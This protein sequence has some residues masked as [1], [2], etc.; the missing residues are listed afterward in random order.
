MYLII[1]QLV[2]IVGEL[3]SAKKQNKTRLVCNPATTA[4]EVCVPDEAEESRFLPSHLAQFLLCKS[5]PSL[6]HAVLCCPRLYLPLFPWSTQ[7]C[8]VHGLYLPLFP[9]STH[10]SFLGAGTAVMCHHT[11]PTL[12]AF[13]V[14]ICCSK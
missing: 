8:A 13:L 3:V 1:I 14:A 7:C 4:F 11:W 9:W 5:Q 2:Q 12:Y 6:V 10:F